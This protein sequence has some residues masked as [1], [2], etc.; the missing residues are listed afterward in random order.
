MCANMLPEHVV[1]EHSAAKPMVRMIREPV[2]AVVLKHVS[3]QLPCDRPDASVMVSGDAPITSN[4]VRGSTGQCVAVSATAFSL[5]I[6][7]QTS[8]TVDGVGSATL[9]YCRLAFWSALMCA[10][11]YTLPSVASPIVSSMLSHVEV[12]QLSVS[13]QAQEATHKPACAHAPRRTLFEAPY[14]LLAEAPP[15]HIF[16][17]DQYPLESRRSVSVSAFPVFVV[18]DAPS[19]VVMRTAPAPEVGVAVG[20]WVGVA[21]AGCNV[22]AAVGKLVGAAVRPTKLVELARVVGASV[23]TASGTAVAHSPSTSKL[24]IEYP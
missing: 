17:L 12:T 22:D 21:A 7:T 2:V 6:L 23:G 14:L 24:K 8:L 10:P 13:V 5:R 16:P 4:P 11:V 18:M 20:I 9:M 19:S 3:T 15:L 1:V